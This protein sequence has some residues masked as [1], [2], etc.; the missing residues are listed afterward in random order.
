MVAKIPAIKLPKKDP[1]VTEPKTTW[2]KVVLY[3]PVVVTVIA[4][5][6]AGLSN[7]ELNAAQ[8]DRSWAA[9]L[10]SK[11]ADQWNFFQTKK[12]RGTIMDDGADAAGGWAGWE[13]FSKADAASTSAELEKTGSGAGYAEAAKKLRESLAATES[14]AAVEALERGSP[15]TAPAA[16]EAAREIRDAISAIEALHPE[17]EIAALTAKV[18]P[19]KLDAAVAQAQ[20]RAAA[21]DALTAP[22][23]QGVE[24]LRGLLLEVMANRDAFKFNDAGGAS[25]M[26]DQYAAFAAARMRLHARRYD[27]EAALNKD[28]AQLMELRVR[29]SNM[30]AD[31]H[32]RRSGLFFYAMVAAQGAVVAATMALALPQRG[33]LWTVAAAT[34]TT[35]LGY[36][37]W[38]WTTI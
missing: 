28:I 12:V 35:S 20:Q 38:V 36:G 32:K 16:T 24:R 31:H 11:V 7:S 8:Y 15:P 10:Q 6:L 17:A 33:L 13:R 29:L 5:L 19:M 27:A 23:T 34:G 3:T 26:H 4:T 30:S 37:L 2:D 21:F 9:Q 18:D 1:V 14:Q 22:V 25:T